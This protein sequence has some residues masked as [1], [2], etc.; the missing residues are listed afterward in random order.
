MH[1]RCMS[2]GSHVM[3]LIRKEQSARAHTKWAWCAQGTEAYTG[4]CSMTMTHGVAVRFRFVDI[5]AMNLH[6]TAPTR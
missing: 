3:P 2:V 4:A 1:D 6:S 5:S